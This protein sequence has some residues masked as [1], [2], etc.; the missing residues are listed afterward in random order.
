MKEQLTAADWR[1]RVVAALIVVAFLALPVVAGWY[2]SNYAVT[3]ATRVAILAIVAVSLDMLIGWGGLVSF[4]HAAYFG[5]GGYT[6]AMAAFHLNEGVPLLGWEGSNEALVV[7][8]LAM[9]VAGLG[10]LL[11]GALSLRTSGVYFIMIT[12]AFAQMVYFVFVALKYYGGDDGLSLARRN[13]L[14]GGSIVSAQSFYWVCLACLGIVMLVTSR[15]LNSRFGMVLRGAKASERRMAAL[16]FPVYRYRLAAFTIAGMIAGLAGALWVN[17]NRFASPDMMHWTRS[18]EF[19]VM[20]IL[21]GLA[22]RF[23]P[24]V[25]A[26]AIFLLETWL[27]DLTEHWQVAFGP[28]VVLVALFAPGGLWGFVR[29]Q[30]R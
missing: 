24:V 4:G 25:G 29:G 1:E 12:L 3:L 6:V 19:M 30:R 2:G 26:A 17:V 28:L 20:I 23:G 16:G 13:T 11:F 10:A 27:S 21:G 5:L 22:T 18:G 7:W 8:P 14:A 9:L 15:I